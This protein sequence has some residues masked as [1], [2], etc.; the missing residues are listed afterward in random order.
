MHHTDRAVEQL[1]QPHT[2]HTEAG[3]VEWPPLLTW[4]QQSITTIVTTDGGGTGGLPFNTE[5]LALLDHIDTRIKLMREALNLPPQRDRIATT[6]TIWQHTKTEHAGGRLADT[7]LE[8]ISD[9][10]QHWV[11]RIQAEDDRPRK[12]E[13]TT[14]CPNCGTRWILEDTDRVAA[15][16]IEYKTGTAP[17]AEC[18]NCQ[19]MWAGW[20]DV[21]TLGYTVGAEQDYAILDA[22]GV[23]VAPV[24]AM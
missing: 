20:A 18:R 9:D 13:L 24:T 1:T 4:L 22:C 2:E 7:Q 8:A 19:T 15:V 14:P 11:Q 17:I 5:A 12:M 6:T 3:P 16:R 10:L 23:H 21:A